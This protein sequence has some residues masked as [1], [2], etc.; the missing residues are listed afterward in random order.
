MAREKLT[1]E[2]RTTALAK[3]SGWSEVVKAEWDL[4][5]RRGGGVRLLLLGSSALLLGRGSSTLRITCYPPS[6]LVILIVQII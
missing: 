6:P 2:A 1:G 3:L 4:E 5:L